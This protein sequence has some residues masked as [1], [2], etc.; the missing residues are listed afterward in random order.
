MNALEIRNL[1][2]TFPIRS[3]FG[4][5]TGEVRAVDDVSFSIPVG[6]VYGLAGE[7]GSGK[8]TIA[9]MIMGLAKPDS[10]DIL[11]DGQSLATG[12]ARGKVQMV[13]Q[14]PGASLNPRRTVG[15][16]IRVPLVAHGFAGDKAARVGQLLEMVQLPKGFADRYPHELSGGQK[17]RVA[18][19]RALAV[20]PRLLVLDEPTSALDVSV[21]AKVIDLLETLGRELNLTYLFISHDLSLMRNFAQVVGVLY[22]GRI[23]ETGPVARVFERPEHDYTR[24]L[25]ASVPVV[26]EEEAAMRPV[27]PLINGELPTAEDLL[28]LRASSLKGQNT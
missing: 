15:Q 9:R 25:L 12:T 4:R 11:L 23:V 17:Q 6:G 21:Q 16:S 3:G 2:K 7:S 22:R 20:E 14:N 10:G 24:L 8:S 26:S 5:V 28:A 19:A 13:F 1:V 18:I 27:I